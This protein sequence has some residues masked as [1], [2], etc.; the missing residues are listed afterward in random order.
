MM[1]CAIGILSDSSL[2]FPGFKD[3]SDVI[4]LYLGDDKTDED[5]FKVGAISYSSRFRFLNGPHLYV[6]LV[7]SFRIREL[8]IAC[9]VLKY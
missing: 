5:A 2:Q 7:E 4:P 3:T 6:V 8:K 1:L 9:I